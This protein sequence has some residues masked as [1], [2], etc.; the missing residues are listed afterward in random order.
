MP[1]GKARRP[2]ILVK[3]NSSF[4]DKCSFREFH[5]EDR[6]NLMPD[7]SFMGVDILHEHRWADHLYRDA[8]FFAELADH[9]SLGGFAELYRTAKRANPL[10]DAAI[11]QNFGSKKPV[12]APVQP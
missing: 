4:P 1:L 2:I 9:G 8:E 7:A 5:I 6:N 10:D 12:V 3:L 11:I